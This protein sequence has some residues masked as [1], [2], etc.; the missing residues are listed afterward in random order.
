MMFGAMAALLIYI[1][2]ITILAPNASEH[3]VASLLIKPVLILLFLCILTPSSILI[4]NLFHIATIK[5]LFTKMFHSFVFGG[6][7]SFA[8]LG[9]FSFFN[10][11]NL[12]AYGKYFNMFLQKELL[13]ALLLIGGPV[14]LFVVML[15]SYWWIIKVR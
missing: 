13:L 6:V 15:M 14:V 12:V 8:V 7:Y 10:S 1:T 2:L 3:T 5:F 4:A 9:A 11:D